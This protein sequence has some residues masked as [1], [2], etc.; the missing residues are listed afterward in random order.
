MTPQHSGAGAASVPGPAPPPAPSDPAAPLTR[1]ETVG[2][3]TFLHSSDWQLGMVRRFLG[4]DAQ[5]RFGQARIDAIARIG[6]VAA[7]VGAAF[8]VVAGDVFD[9]N[10]VDRQVVL[11]ACEALRAVPCPVY[12]LPGNHDALEPGSVWMCPTVR[13]HLPSHVEVLSDS[14]PRAAA[15]GVEV[16]GVPW[17]TR[18]PHADPVLADLTPPPARPGVRRVLVGHGQVDSLMPDAHLATTIALD[19]LQELLADGAVDYVALGDRHSRTPIGR[20]GRVWYSG[21][22]EPTR[23]EEEAP[24]DVLVV[25]LADGSC[26]VT[27]VPVATWRLVS[28]VAEIDGPRDLDDLE[29]W[30]AELPD[31]TRTVVRLGV[32]GTLSIADRTRLELL[33]DANADLFGALRRW[34]P[35]WDVVPRP[36]DDTLDAM[37]LAGAAR[38]ALDELRSATGGGDDEAGDALLLLHRL[39][40]GA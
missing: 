40:Q 33:L 20:T 10:Q 7:E 12:L 31:K 19:G 2:E 1:A 38:A 28:H 22:P 30:L 29:A 11:R 35:H 37:P 5:A 13:H 16:I 26:R 17:R 21:S 23:P 14:R 3:V 24:G 36:D 32:R 15:P 4:A 6:A 34:E 9:A 39:A 8:V 25:T 18:R 27:P